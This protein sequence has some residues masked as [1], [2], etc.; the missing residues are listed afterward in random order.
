[1]ERDRTIT[2]WE[3]VAGNDNEG[4]EIILQ[5]MQSLRSAIENNRSSKIASDAEELEEFADFEDD[6]ELPE[7]LKNILDQDSL[8]D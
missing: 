6:E 7:T 5:S 2:S 3:C 8:L 1:M 4:A